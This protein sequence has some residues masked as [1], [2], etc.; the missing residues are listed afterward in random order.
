M[1]VQRNFII[2]D[3]WLYFKIYTGTKTADVLL[4]GEIL[5]LTENLFKDG[6]IDKWFF[7]RYADPDYHIR[8]RFHLAQPEYMYQLI[9]LMNQLIKPYLKNDLVSSIKVDTYKRELERYG[10][11]SIEQSEELFLHDSV[12][13]GKALNFLK[14]DETN[15]LRWLFGVRAIDRLLSDFQFSEEEKMN[16]LKHLKINFAQEFWMGKSLRKQLSKKFTIYRER[17]A[18]FLAIDYIKKVEE[19][20]LFELIEERSLRNRVVINSIM[21]I[22]P[23]LDV[24][25]NDLLSSY[26]HMHCNRLFK[27]K[28]R[29]HEMVIYDLLFQH[30]KSNL[31]RKIYEHNGVSRKAIIE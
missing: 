22:G 30:Y 9:H 13:I 16:L 24:S 15:E 7:I 28:Q 14:G 25:I 10:F 12:M 21:K 29:V 3:E 5:N 6:C 2:G 11:M 20:N 23:N 17:I 4:A 1:V 26:I 27:S 18:Y 31:A 8:L 19:R